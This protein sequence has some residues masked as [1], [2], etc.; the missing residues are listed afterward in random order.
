LGRELP[1]TVGPLER[2]FPQSL[3]QIFLPLPCAI[4]A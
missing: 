3:F 2:S 4:I 1:E